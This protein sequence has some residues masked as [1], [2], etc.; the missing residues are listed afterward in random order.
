MWKQGALPRKPKGGAAAA[1]AAAMVVAMNRRLASWAVKRQAGLTQPGR[2]ESL[3]P[4]SPVGEEHLQTLVAFLQ[5]GPIY[6]HIPS[7]RGSA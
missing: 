2:F 3:T 4:L 1:A 7:R 5:V 6:S